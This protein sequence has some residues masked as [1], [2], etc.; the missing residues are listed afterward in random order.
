MVEPTTIVLEP[1]DWL[2]EVCL[3]P[4]E[5]VIRLRQLLFGIAEH[6]LEVWNAVS[7]VDGE[8]RA[9]L[10]P[11]EADYVSKQITISSALF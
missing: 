3:K 7:E 4:G 5:V 6:I 9:V 11:R 2:A 10:S 8:R 1:H